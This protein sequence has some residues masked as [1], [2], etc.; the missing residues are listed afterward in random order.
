MLVVLV[1]A[2]REVLITASQQLRE[3]LSSSSFTKKKLTI[4]HIAVV[5]RSHFGLLMNSMVES[6]SDNMGQIGQDV[7]IHIPT[8]L[9]TDRPTD[10]RTDTAELDS[11]FVAGFE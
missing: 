9:P 2:V 4:H 8:Y 5:C 7:S 3:T 6:Y 10:Q 1:A 11:V